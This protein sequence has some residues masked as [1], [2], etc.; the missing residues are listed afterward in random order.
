MQLHV[1]EG[2]DAPTEPLVSANLPGDKKRE[3]RVAEGCWLLR[4]LKIVKVAVEDIKTKVAHLMTRN[5]MP[6]VGHP[7][8]C[9]APGCRC[10]G[11]AVTAPS[12]ATSS[13]QLAATKV[14]SGQLELI[15]NCPDS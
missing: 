2:P 9:S 3:L 13:D 14:P 11:Q 5:F 12:L 6:L 7:N 8:F 15:C 4:G 10:H 1:V